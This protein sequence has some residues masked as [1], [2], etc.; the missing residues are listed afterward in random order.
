[1]SAAPEPFSRRL[2]LL[3]KTVRERTDLQPKLGLVLG[4]GLGGLADE[5]DIAASIPF[6]DLPGWPPPSAPGHS[7]RLLM[8]VLRGLPVACLQGRLHLYEGHSAR[9]VVEPALLLHRLGAQRLLLTNAAGG[10]DP[11]FD[12]GTL[13]LIR[14]HINLTGRDPL[15]GPNDDALGTRFPDMTF[16]WDAELSEGLRRAAHTESVDLAEGV[17]VGLT[18]PTY[19]TPAEVR[20]L[21]A[22]GGHAVGMSTVMEAIAAHWAGSRVCGVS[23]VTNK[24][25]G[26]SPTTLTHEEVLEAAAVAGP[27]LARVIGRFAEQLASELEPA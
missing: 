9:L 13:M 16:V 2:D 15:V 14:D 26:L 10:L 18:G 11:A 23:L 25:A 12:A 6:A 27:R 21:H 20:M 8:G 7:G 1:V 4:S 17:Y 5:V 19:E 24:G 3:E 22:L